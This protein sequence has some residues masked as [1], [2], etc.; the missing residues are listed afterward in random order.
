MRLRLLLTGNE[1][2]AGDIIDSNSAKIAAKIAP[3]GWE[4]E[5]KVTVGDHLALLCE[6]IDALCQGADVLL[7]NG[8]L[9]PTVDDLTSQALANV[10]GRPISEHP[11]AL[12]HLTTWCETRGFA[13][14]QANRKQAMLPDGCDIIDNPKGSAVGISLQHKGCLVLATPG[15]PSELMVMLD[16]VILP[17]LQQHFPSDQLRIRRFGVFGLGEST[18]QERVNQQLQNWPEQIDLGFRASMPVLEVKLSAGADVSDADL[19]HWC[20]RVKAVLH[21]HLLGEIPVS[22]PSALLDLLHAKGLKLCTAESCTGGLIAS[23]ITT[24]PGASQSFV[25]SV[26]SYSNAIKQ[27]LLSVSAANLHQFGAVS[28]EVVI[29]MA[30]G[31]LNAMAADTVIAVT[32][33]AGPDGGTPEKPNG[34]VW[35]AWGSA[36]NLQTARFLLPFDREFF[37]MWAAALG[38]DLLRRQLA[39]LPELSSLG[40]RF[41]RWDLPRGNTLL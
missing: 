31:A 41:Q 29:E 27:H 16:Q 38:M 30:R 36:D 2:M 11:A 9:G 19:D 28:E 39:G 40:Q 13:L 12:A 7:I 35:L 23:Q 14:G 37:Q 8:G 15:V 21:D 18:I 1:L 6:Q 3:L 17:R 4:I 33:I 34:T 32:G 20:D 26:V 5:R 25:G 24:V 10:T 22:L